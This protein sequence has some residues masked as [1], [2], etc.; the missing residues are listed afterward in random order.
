MGAEVGRVAGA[1]YR[2]VVGFRPLELDLYL[3]Q[4]VPS[5]RP[6]IVSV[7]G[8]GWQ[9]GS[10]THA[11]PVLGGD[12][13]AFHSA[14]AASGFAV[15]AVDYRLS[16][17][18]PCPAAVDDLCAAVHWLRAEHRRLRLDPA[19]IVLWGESA[20]AH[21]ALLAAL[22]R[23]DPLGVRGVVAWFPPTDLPGLP[24]DLRAL[25]GAGHEPD[26]SRED[27]FLGAPV[28]AEPE[29]ARAASPLA[30]VHPGAPPILLAHGTAD[31]HVPVAQSIRLAAALREVGAPV[32]L[33]LV[34]G[35]GHF[36]DDAPDVPR[37]VGD[38]LRFCRSVT[39]AAAPEPE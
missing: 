18:A 37:L 11:L 34:A 3:P 39:G 8:G 38:A 16:G 22:R 5:D 35:A 14:V 36:W 2:E 21:L 12:G 24:D 6:V 4:H 19:A 26:T 29:R 33:D 32:R 1:V 17:E 25:H 27:R 13:P 7:H 28:A 9:R 31:R 20:G 15:A 30:H 23:S 10:R